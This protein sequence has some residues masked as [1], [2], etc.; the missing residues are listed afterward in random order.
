LHEFGHLFVAKKLGCG[1]DIFS[2][3]FGKP[4]YRKEYKE[5]IY[6]IA[7]IP[8]G[9]YCKLRDELINSSDKTAFSNQPYYKK[10]LIVIAGCLANMILGIVL[11]IIGLK[12]LNFN[13]YYFGIISLALGITNLL[14][15]P[16]LDGSY[17]YLVWLEKFYGKEKGCKIMEK[18]CRIG[19]IILMTLNILYLPYLFYS[20]WIGKL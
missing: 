5:T 4:I 16:A 8:L 14:P 15:F 1:V 17:P 20:L 18:V 3:G 13:I 9:G 7:L 10:I 6:Q 19:F 12:L 11:Y 2:I